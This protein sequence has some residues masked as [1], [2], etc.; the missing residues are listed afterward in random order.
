MTID[1]G[2]VRSLGICER[3]SV[4]SPKVYCTFNAEKSETLLP[5][6]DN[7]GCKNDLNY[8]VSCFLRVSVLVYC[9]SLQ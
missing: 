3:S 9:E 8:R 6:L 5:I 4:K 1:D 2:R 7:S